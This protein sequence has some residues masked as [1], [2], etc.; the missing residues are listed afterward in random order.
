MCP[1]TS[2]VPPV[3]TAV[4]VRKEDR[5]LMYYLTSSIVVSSLQK[6]HWDWGKKRLLMMLFFGAVCYIFLKS[7]GTI[8]AMDSSK[9]LVLDTKNLKGYW[10]NHGSAWHETLQ[11]QTVQAGRHRGVRT[12]SRRSAL[13]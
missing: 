12:S 10:D 13:L 8:L 2:C 5:A 6:K 4:T 3:M 1:S 7:S 11:L 9:V